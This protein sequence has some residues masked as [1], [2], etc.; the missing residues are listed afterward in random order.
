VRAVRK[1]FLNVLTVAMPR[2]ISRKEK[3]V[4]D[5]IRTVW[6]ETYE[7]WDLVLYRVGDVYYKVRSTTE[8]TTCHRAG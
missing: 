2:S 3:A 1:S 8:R 7:L 6:W 5:A 4:D